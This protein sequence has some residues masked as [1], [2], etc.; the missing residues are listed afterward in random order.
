M[1]QAIIDQLETLIKEEQTDELFSK[2]EELGSEY[3]KACDQHNHELLDLFVAGGGASADFEAPKDPLD[4]HFNELIHI[5]ND[6]E[7]KFKKQ[8]AREASEK[9][10]AKQ[11]IVTDLE[12][13]VGEETNIGRAFQQFKDL[14]A[15]WNE[16]GNVPLKEYKNV[17]SAYH[18]HVHNF[19]YNMKLSKDLKELDFKRNLEHRTA[20]LSKIES[21]NQMES[22]K[23]MERLLNL[24]RMEWSELGP[25]APETIEPLRTRYRELIAQALQ[26]V[27]DFY[28]LRQEDEKKHLEDKKVLLERVQKISEENFDNARQ[29]QTMTETIEKILDEWKKIGYAPKGDNDKV[30]HDLR[31]AINQFYTKKRNFFGDLKKIYKGNKEK[32]LAI[33][34]KAEAICNEAHETWDEPTQKIIQLQRDWK[35]AGQIDYGD[36]NKLWK[37]FR[38]SCDKFFNS[39]NEFFKLRDADQYKNLE[40]KEELIKRLEDFQLTGNAEE[41]L[42]TL[43]DFSA[44]W[45]NIPHVPFKDK[46]RVYGKYKKALDAKYDSMKLE[47]GQMHLLKFRN[48]I[49]M[50][51]GSDHS[52][53]LI[54]KERNTI[55][56]RIHKLQGTINQYENNMGF[57]THS[58]NMG[59]LL[60]EVEENLAKAKEE[61][62]LLKKKLKMLTE[63]KPA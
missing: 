26:R 10:V 35:D 55:K 38:E 43:K 22:I 6:R 28:H 4:N 18:R 41:D 47:S 36:E 20:L 58:K 42:K 16:V 57:F 19:Y 13:L 53:K 30:W 31:S 5:L 45:K 2:A 49:E 56:D 7:K 54:S 17:Q 50:L 11:Q 21:L 44:E 62:E 48:N 23:G 9:L 60:K 12:K 32:K 8:H 14:Q 15:K 51:A 61:M 29:W 39:K 33:I 52:D 63:A 1:K 24:Y 46:E 37:K 25:T 59:G 34:A 40:L 27:R 3:L